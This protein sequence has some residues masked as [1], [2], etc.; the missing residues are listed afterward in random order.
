MN[1]NDLIAATIPHRQLAVTSPGHDVGR[2]I[3]DDCIVFIYPDFESDQFTTCSGLQARIQMQNFGNEN[4][5][6]KIYFLD[7]NCFAVVREVG[8]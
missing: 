5:T 6:Y 2:Y 3:P 7:S 1:L 8:Q 4:L